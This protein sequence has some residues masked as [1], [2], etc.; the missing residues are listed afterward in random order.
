MARKHPTMKGVG[1]ALFYALDMLVPLHITSWNMK[2]VQV[3]LKQRIRSG[4]TTDRI[5]N[6]LNDHI[7]AEELL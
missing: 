6:V 4:K 2:L 7:A 3:D 5:V 1:K